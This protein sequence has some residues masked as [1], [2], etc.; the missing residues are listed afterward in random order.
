[1]N[2]FD[3][4]GKTA[5]ITGASS[6]IGRDFARQLA[7][8]GVALILVARRA[9]AAGACRRVSQKARRLHHD[10]RAGFSEAGSHSPLWNGLKP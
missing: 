8:R 4:T 2:S 9:K 7:A 5:L 3:Y 10:Y 6:G 1:M